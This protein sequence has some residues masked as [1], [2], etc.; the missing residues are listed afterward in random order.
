MSSQILLNNIPVSPAKGITPLHPS[1]HFSQNCREKETSSRVSGVSHLEPNW[2]GIFNLL[3]TFQTVTIAYCAK[4]AVLCRLVPGTVMWFL[5]D[6]VMLMTLTSNTYSVIFPFFFSQHT[7]ICSTISEIGYILPCRA[8]LCNSQQTKIEVTSEVS[9]IHQHA[10]S[11]S[12]SSWTP[13]TPHLQPGQCKTE[14]VSEKPSLIQN[15]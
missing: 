15:N 6:S 1:D 5:W 8:F 3:N 12:P 10:N 11:S 14:L 13:T 7:S 4:L 2:K 9:K